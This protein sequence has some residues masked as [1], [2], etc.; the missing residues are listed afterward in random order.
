MFGI[1]GFNAAMGKRKKQVVPSPSKS[2]PRENLKEIPADVLVN[3]LSRLPLEDVARCRCVSKH[4][5]SVLRRRDFT[6]LYLEV[7]SARPRI[8]F[9]FVH[10]GKRI[11]Y[12]ILQDV[13]PDRDYSNAISPYYQMHFPK[14]LGS[15][16]DACPSIRAFI[17]NKYR[18]PMICNPSTRQYIS[19]PISTTKGNQM[20]P[21]F[22][23]DPIGKVFKVF[24]VSDDFVCRVTTL[25]TE[26][27][28][29]RRVEC[30]IPHWPLHSEICIDGVL[31]YLVGCLED[32][33]RL[34]YRV[35]CFD[36]K[37]EKLKFVGGVVGSLILY[38]SF[39]NY[40]GKLASATKLVKWSHIVYEFPDCWFDFVADTDIKIVGMTSAGEIILSTCSLVEPLYVFY[41]NVNKNTLTRVE[42]DFEIVGKKASNSQVSTLINHVENVK[43]MD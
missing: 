23:Y 40:H 7:S 29:W 17:C 9:T 33:T 3:V 10:E 30:L 42:I 41:F 13:D 34:G 28:T 27:V 26:V 18:K 2:P 25:G 5:S 1:L 37:L 22:G 36:V 8:L 4:W 20:R 43:L 39:I 16:H 14:G 6:Q 38:S 12:S 32:G 15:F 31:Y 35:V 19:L 24:C 11:F 21:Y